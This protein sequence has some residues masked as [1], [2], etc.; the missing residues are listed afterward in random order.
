MKN[1]PIILI[2]LFALLHLIL[3]IT[4]TFAAYANVRFYRLDTAFIS[5]LIHRGL[6]ILS[7]ILFTIYLFA[8]H[9]KKPNHVLLPIAYIFTAIHYGIYFIQ[10]IESIKSVFDTSIIPQILRSFILTLSNNFFPCIFFTFFGIVCFTKFKA[11]KIARIVIIISS[12]LAVT[13]IL[14][15]IPNVISNFQ[16][17]MKFNDNVLTANILGYLSNLTIIFNVIANLILWRAALPNKIKE[18]A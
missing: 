6:F 10:D 5:I 2:R 17:F 18:N 1:K 9:E 12:A 7:L 16:I 8:F 14:I 15:N 13:S 11:I 4:L 3:F